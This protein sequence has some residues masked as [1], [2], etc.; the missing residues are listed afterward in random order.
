MRQRAIVLSLFGLLLTA[1]AVSGSTGQQVPVR[2]I[3]PA[4]VNMTL[5]GIDDVMERPAIEF[6]HAAHVKTLEAEGCVT[7]HTVDDKGL[8]TSLKAVAGIEGK[9]ALTDAFHDTCTGCHQRRSG[10]GKTSGP[11]TCGNC[12]V[13]LEP[14]VSS[15]FPI[16]FDRSLHA[17]HD[18][19][20]PEDCA[21]CHHIWDE[22]TKALVHRENTEEACRDCH[23]EVAVDNQPSLRSAV[24]RKCVGCH[25]E[26]ADGGEETGPVRC[27][28]CHDRAVVGAIEQLAEIPRLMRAQPNSLW[29]KGPGATQS[30]VA[31]NHENHEKRTAS[32]S[33]CH[34]NRMKPCADCHTLI[35][36]EDGGGVILERAHHDRGSARSCIGCH[37]TEAA[38]G[39]CAGCHRDTTIAGDGS[40]SCGICHAGPRPQPEE[41]PAIADGSPVVPELDVLPAASDDLPEEVT[42]DLLVDSYEASKFPH[43]KIIRRFDD[44]IRAS[45]LARQ[46]HGSTE[47]MCSGCHHHSPAGERP[48]KCSACHGDEAA[49]TADRP[50]L[51]VAYHRQCLSCHQRLKIKAGCTDCHAV[52]EGQS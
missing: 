4:T 29:V 26:R 15:R 51:K 45:V 44:G 40:S 37:R 11:V 3:Q 7:C 10:E 9:N 27:E 19:A 5:P 43:L 47:A 32:C 12:H 6:N 14:G 18:K 2:M 28:G 31:F 23:G 35:P 36:G 30:L 49:A 48:P 17:R 38:E 1:V 34:H 13:R 46:F 33:S 21:K 39:D 50:S 24:H 20:F 8:D 42:I 25:L 52:K 41:M 16:A 22:A